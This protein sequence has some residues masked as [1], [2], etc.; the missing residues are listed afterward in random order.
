[1]NEREWQD[2]LAALRDV[3]ETDTA[4]DAAAA[5]QARSTAE[6]VPRLIQLLSDTDIFVRE[7]A[8]WPL[9][10]VGCVEAIPHLVRAHHAGTDEGHDNDSLSAALADLVSM[11][12]ASALP[13][14]RALEE[15][16]DS[17]TRETAKWLLGFCEAPH[18]A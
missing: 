4:V 1:M 14:L 3:G 15:C 9:S 16:A 10:D 12:A 8:A 7:A 2:L 17:R 13:V 18:D 11:N 6:D 5:L